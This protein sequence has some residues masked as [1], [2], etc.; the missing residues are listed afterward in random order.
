[1]TEL[2]LLNEPP[3]EFRYGQ[4]TPDP[5]DGL[6]L[7]GPFDGDLASRPGNMRYGLIGTR[8]GM[9]Q[10]LAFSTL[11]AG[12]IIPSAEFDRDLWPPFPGFDVAFSCDWP[13]QPA[14]HA[15][16]DRE[17]L[18]NAAGIGEHHRRVYAVAERFLEPIRIA[19]QRDEQLG[20]VFCVVP[21]E[22]YR[23]CRVQSQ[24]PREEMT[25][26]PLSPRTR[27]LIAAGQD[28]LFD[29][30]AVEHYLYSRD[31]R[32]QLKARS[33]AFGI[34]VQI[35]RETTLRLTDTNRNP[36]ERGLTTLADR[37]W[38]LGT[39]AYY[40]AGGK[41]WR[42]ASARPGVCY[43]GLAFRR[44]SSS[45]RG[46]TAVCAAQMFLESGDGIVFKGETGPW[47]SPER[48]DYHL[49][50]EAAES[51][52][53]GVIETYKAL[54]G[55]PLTE[56]FLHSRSEISRAEF[57]GYAR[58]VPAEIK[59]VGIRVRSEGSD[60]LRLFRP[61]S[62]PVIRGTFWQLSPRSGLLWGS[63]FVPRLRE[64]PGSEVPVPVRIDIQHG[65][66]DLV[67]V[68]R[69]V[70]SLTKLNYNACSF[71]DREPVTIG[72]S[73]KVGEIL[74]ANPATAVPQPQFRYYI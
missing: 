27:K 57:E 17:G 64:Y 10:F 3:L 26:A 62:R 44:A 47:Y 71:G 56:V 45:A 7:F 63:G 74:V 72:F 68:A 54:G 60:G 21:E 52:L 6:A 9:D 59:L 11:V 25:S 1:M 70:L 33:M 51:L 19:A 43:I 30:R 61:G 40:K 14:W 29:K 32:R 66:A 34:P 23:H 18:R 39:T 4:E 38:N 48:N 20:L 28:D 13:T 41:P 36:F 5:H 42:L 31:F 46:N 15:S 49:S 16:V 37:A 73:D 69:D 35:V 2:H 58:A 8:E 65:D 53:T 55:L 50:P 12:P 22:V 67:Q 24:I